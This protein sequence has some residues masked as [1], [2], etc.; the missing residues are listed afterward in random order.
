M[1]NPD[2]GDIA[3]WIRLYTPRLLGVARAFAYGPDEAEDI[4]QEVWITAHEKAHMRPA[5]SPLGAWLYTLTLNEGRSRLRRFHRRARLRELWSLDLGPREEH[6]SVPGVGE[7]LARSRLWREVARLPILQREALLLRVVEGMN[8]R[9]TAEILDRADG[10][11]K[12]SLHR[13]LKALRRELQEEQSA[14]ERSAEE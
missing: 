5:G 1:T 9:E 12:A 14:S 13:A 3:E 6:A 8:T 10:T 7:E 2:P 11:I 4:L